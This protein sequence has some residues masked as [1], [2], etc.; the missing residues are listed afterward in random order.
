MDLPFDENVVGHLLVLVFEVA[1]FQCVFGIRSNDRS[2]HACCCL[3]VACRR[4]PFYQ[5]VLAPRIRVRRRQIL[6]GVSSR[7]AHEQSVLHLLRPDVVVDEVVKFDVVKDVDLAEDVEPLDVLGVVGVLQI[8]VAVETRSTRALPHWF[9]ATVFLQVD[10]PLFLSEIVPQFLHE[11]PRHVELLE[12]YLELQSRYGIIFELSLDQLQHLDCI[13]RRLQKSKVLR[14]S[15]SK[16]PS[17][18][19]MALK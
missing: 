9:R 15:F 13:N 3:G 7:L 5:Q 18:I 8:A 17:T 12:V 11:E 14:I 6:V 10:C 4:T 16:Y 19:R 2:L 1:W